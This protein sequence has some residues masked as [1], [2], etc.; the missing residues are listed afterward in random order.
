VKLIVY[1]DFNCPYSALASCRVDEL[2]RNGTAEVDWRA[3]EHEPEIPPDGR[4]MD[5]DF[6]KK[7]EA[8]LDE[9]A[10]LRRPDEAFKPVLPEIYPN[11]RETSRVFST[12]QGD[13]ADYYRREAFEAVWGRGRNISDAAVLGE[14]G[15]GLREPLS[16]AWQREWE[17]IERRA[18]PLI[19]EEDGSIA[20]GKEA[21]ALLDRLL[22]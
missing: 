9:I 21:L 8:E 14:T 16:D 15:V 18:V 1:A 4:P 22:G 3:V 5:G 2:V 7:I 10:E 17:E 11:T 20:R 12:W 19:V 13:A 6:R